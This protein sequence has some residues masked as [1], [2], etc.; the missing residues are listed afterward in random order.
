[1]VLWMLTFSIEIS[2][3]CIRNYLSK[4]LR[5]R[6]IQTIDHTVIVLLITFLPIYHSAFFKCFMLTSRVHT[7]SRTE[8]FIWTTGVDYSNSVNHDWVQV[9]N[10]C[11]YS[12]LFL[13]VVGIEPATSR[14]FHT[15]TLSNQSL[16]PLLHVLLSGRIWHATH[17][18][19]QRIYRLKCYVYNNKDEVNSPNIQSNNK[20]W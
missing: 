6:L 2:L 7:E 18:G 1:M 14:W 10:Y 13:P 17:E 5:W 15:E 4:F 11:K 16:Y 19:N 20:Y 9:L 12:L 8:P 3:S